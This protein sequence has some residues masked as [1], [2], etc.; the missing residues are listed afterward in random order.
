MKEVPAVHYASRSGQKAVRSG[1]PN[2]RRSSPGTLASYALPEQALAH[3]NN[4][5]SRRSKEGIPV[6]KVN[7]VSS[8]VGWMDGWMEGRSLSLY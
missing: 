3:N 8:V 1:V 6:Y 5:H 4:S 7:K 2:S